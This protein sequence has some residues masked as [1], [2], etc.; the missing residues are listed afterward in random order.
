MPAISGL[1]ARVFGPGRFVRTAYRVREGTPDVSAFC[2]VAVLGDRL[3]AA[4]R[5]TEIAIGGRGGALLLGPLAVDPDFANQGH[6]RRLIAESIAAAREHGRELVLLVGDMPYYG[7][8]GF[9]PVPKGQIQMPGPVDLARLLALELQTA[10]IERF[11]G[12]VA[13][14]AAPNEE[15][16][17]S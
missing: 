11:R 17:R 1:S 16:P 8:L 10:A 4:I 2:R 13:A 14:A 5:M 6:G 3:V 7:R 12:G 9:S 15:A